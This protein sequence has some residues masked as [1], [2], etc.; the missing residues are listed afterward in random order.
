MLYRLYVDEVGNHDMTHA[1]DL[2]QR[3][4]SLTGVILETD[5][6]TRILRPELEQ[7]KTEFFRHDPDEPIIFHRKELVNK[8]PP[9]HALQKPE[10]EQ[11]FNM[12][13]LK[14]LASWNY[15]VITIVLDK[16]AHRE[17]YA[18]WR[19]H[20]YHY[21]M[22]ALLERF[23]LFLHYADK[24][25]D[26]MVEQRGGKEDRQLKDSYQRLWERGNENIP[27]ERWQA[28]LT[29]SELKVKPKTANVA[30]LQ[31]ADL[32][33]HPSRREI[34]LE[35]QLLVDQRDIFGDQISAILRQ[36]KY[37]RHV[38]TGQIEGYGKKLLP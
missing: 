4:L 21:C 2:N 33:A 5:Y 34:L 27:V 10:V 28:H 13:L 19:F 36:D 3:F 30:G 22:T 23:V 24:R 12:R 17:R 25:G 32:V 18:V 20:P 8:R 37:H 14:A 29:S 16:L 38:R 7:I 9:F 11:Q 15:R 6:T 26:I 31:I 35:H 1:D